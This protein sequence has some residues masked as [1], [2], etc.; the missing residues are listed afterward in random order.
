MNATLGDMKRAG[1]MNK[2][3]VP[4]FQAFKGF[5]SW[6]RLP[7]PEEVRSM[8]YAALALGA[9]GA[10]FYPYYSSN[11]NNLS[12]AST[13]ES[14]KSFARL[15]LELSSLTS[16]LVER[17]AKVQPKVKLPEGAKAQVV[18]LLKDGP[19]GRLLI[20]V[21]VSEEAADAAFDL[22]GGSSTWEAVSEKREVCAE[23]GVL[24]DRFGARETHVYRERFVK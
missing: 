21:N 14:F 2:G 11:T 8:T 17:D 16:H 24:R 13:R 18:R 1:G 15:A 12:I 7:T 10:T 23:R 6:H 3:L 9:R 22:G 19:D 5:S 4:V 20:A